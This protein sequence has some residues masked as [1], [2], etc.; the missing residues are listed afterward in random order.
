MFISVGKNL[1][2]AHESDKSPQNSSSVTPLHLAAESGHL[3]ILI[4]T[5]LFGFD[6]D[7]GFKNIFFRNK[8]FLFFK[9]ESRNFQHM[10]ET[11]FRETS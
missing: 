7:N 3:S 5:K 8:T 1:I 11:E 2:L 9:K 6:I 4:E 10:F